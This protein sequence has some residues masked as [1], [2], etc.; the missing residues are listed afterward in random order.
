MPRIVTTESRPRCGWFPEYS[1]WAPP[2]CGSNRGCWGWRSWSASSPASPPSSSSSPASRFALRA[3]CAGRVLTGRPRQRAASD[4]GRHRP[5]R[6]WMLL[7]IAP[8]GGLIS[9]FLVYTFDPRR[10]GTAPTRPSKPYHHKQGYIRPL[11][12]V[13]KIITSASR[14]APAAR[15]GV[16]GPSPRR[17]PASAHS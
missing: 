16:R 7:L 17:A 2:G 4:R 11:V 12:P 8:I 13:I 9:G 15:A 5:L 10:K 14:S 3:Q 6:P 1:N